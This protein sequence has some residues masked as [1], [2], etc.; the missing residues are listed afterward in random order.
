MLLFWKLLFSWKNS[1]IFNT[2][3][4]SDIDISSVHL[5]YISRSNSFSSTN[6]PD[7]SSNYALS[8]NS[9]TEPHII[10]YSTIDEKLSL[11]ISNTNIIKNSDDISI[12][13]DKPKNIDISS[14]LII[15]TENIDNNIKNTNFCKQNGLSLDI[16]E[17]S[18]KEEN[19]PGF[20]TIL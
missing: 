8:D 20:C 11:D 12:T 14:L 2:N 6:V 9:N 7:N 1:L 19:K 15:H 13:T 10:I 17:I 16:K 3:D 4:I 18:S 5:K